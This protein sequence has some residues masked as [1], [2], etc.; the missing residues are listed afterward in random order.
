MH[1]TAYNEEAAGINS[2][3]KAR[4][5]P[6]CAKHATRGA[7]LANQPAQHSRLA[8]SCS[9]DHQAVDAIARAAAAARD[10]HKRIGDTRVEAEVGQI[11]KS[12]GVIVQNHQAVM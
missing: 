3:C 2:R 6:V 5:A 10:N 9:T 8:A 11:P 7:V 4:S 1:A 12:F